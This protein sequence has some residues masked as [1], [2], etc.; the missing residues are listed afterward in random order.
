MQRLLA[1]NRTQSRVVICLLTGHN[2]L[3]IHVHLMKLTNSPLYVRCGVQDENSAHVF[4][5]C[6]TWASLRHVYLGYVFLDLEDIK[7]LSLGPSGILAKE[8]SSPELVSDCGAQR[9]RFKA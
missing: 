6:E 4:C 3:R 2:T 8:R 7:I 5:D 1:F 9:A